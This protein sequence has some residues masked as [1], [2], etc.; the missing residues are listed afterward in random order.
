MAN[1]L[2]KRQQ[3]SLPSNSE[4]NPRREGKEHV[5]AITLRSGRE[6]ATMGQPLMVREMEIEEVY[7]AS[8]KDQ[9]QGEQPQEKKLLR[10]NDIYKFITLLPK[11]YCLIPSNGAKNL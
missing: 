4:V 9:M 2:T 7:Q 11:D 10:P 8:Q 3:G 1:L 5:K 6:L